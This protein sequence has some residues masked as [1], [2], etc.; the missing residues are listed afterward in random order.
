[1]DNMSQAFQKANA[2]FNPQ[3]AEV[4]FQPAYDRQPLSTTLTGSIGWF[5]VPK[6]GASTLIR[7]QTNSAMQKT[8]RD[9]NFPQPGADNNKDYLL[10]GLTMAL[11]PIK[12]DPTDTHAPWIR[13]D[14]D[15]IREGG[16]LNF[17][18]GDKQILDLPLMNI[19]E[20][21]AES[22]VSATTSGSA[23]YAGPQFAIPMLDFQEPIP[24]MR[25]QVINLSI[26]WDGSITLQQAFDLMLMFPA[27]T[28]R[29]S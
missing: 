20:F 28:K 5:A 8:I 18:I 24:L 11:I 29:D 2:I 21:N 16:V 13:A 7:Y 9:T 6:G 1:M 10:F 3:N 19:P 26:T 14:K 17:K 23:V 25:G 15:Y 22:G 12:H 4:F 27:V